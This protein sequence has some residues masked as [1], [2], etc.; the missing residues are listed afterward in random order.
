MAC[1]KDSG[2]DEGGARLAMA[3]DLFDTAVELMRAR[4]K[5]ENP[6]ASAA[7]VDARV[8]LWL[9][10]RPG[11]EFGDAIGRPRPFLPSKR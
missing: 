9:L 4:L 5:R 7:E 8:E 11:A 10:D 3:L 1:M 6:G 2:R